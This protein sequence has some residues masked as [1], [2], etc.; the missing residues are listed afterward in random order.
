MHYSS[1][2]QDAIIAAVA[3]LA[4]APTVAAHGHVASISVNG[5][6]YPGASPN[7]FYLPAN[8]VAAT[9]GWLALNQDN[10]FVEPSK[11]GTSDIACHK[12][13]KSTSV[14]IPVNAGDTVKLQWDT[15]P[16]S[17][18][19]PVIDYLAKV[20]SHS[21]SNAPGSLSF[22]KIAEVGLVNGASPPGT[23][24]SDTLIK[25]GFSWNVKVPSSLAPGSYVLRHEII[26]LHSA[27]NPNGAQNYPQ[28][29]NLVVTG[30]GSTV[31]S[32]VPATSFYK[33]N[34]PGI[35]I[36]IYSTLSSYKVPG[37]SLSSIKKMARHVRDFG[38]EA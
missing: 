29:I 37:P 2:A 20:G 15:W 24:A 10:G 9:A 23:W 38:V 5:K 32:G 16:E 18:H 13:A 35:L 28:C 14:S 36:S 27:G 4:L 8:Q 6:T 30:S 34:D 22:F 11:F 31:P 33:S 17:H 26:G 12:S 7:W 1:F 3:A 19:G 21:A 25:N